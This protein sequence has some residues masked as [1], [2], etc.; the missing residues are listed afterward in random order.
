MGLPVTNLLD[1]ACP[2]RAGEELNLPQL[3]SYLRAHLPNITTP[4]TV[5]QFPRGYSN[6]TYLLRCGEREWVLRRP[7]FGNPV[8]TAHDMGREYRVLSALNKVYP[9]AP[10]ALLY[11]DDPAILGEPF[12][13]MER[14]HGVIL[15]QKVPSGLALDPGTARRLGEAFIDNLAALHR[16]DYAGCGLG[17]LG[18]PAGYV[19]RQV[20]GWI[21]RYR[22]AQTDELPALDLAA[23]WLADHQPTESTAALIHNDYKYD[24][25]VLDPNN[26]THIIAVLDWEMAT[27]GDPLMDLGTTLGY[28]VEAGDLEPLRAAA[29]GPTT[30]P[31]SL[32]R[33]ELVARYE[34]VTG[35]DVSGILFYYV[36]GLFKIAVIAQ[37]IYA[38]Y[39]RGLTK[40]ERFAGL[41]H[42]IALL[43]E[44]AIRAIDTDRLGE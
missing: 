42:M 5:E 21:E 29:F 31:G 30:L 16:I 34:S 32:T 15:R 33:R 35:C 22:K 36:F 19:G 40:D 28:W 39:K 26:L 27:L 18:K 6:L 1:S 8:K 23:R 43:G 12:Y 7:P 3:E 9:P 24:N 10:R 17:D 38:R 37:Q 20:S 2:V 41:I 44:Q 14:R 25:L 13:I 4:A 11:C